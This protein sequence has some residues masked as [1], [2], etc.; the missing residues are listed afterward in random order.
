MRGP[1]WLGWAFAGVMIAL[2]AYCLA[3]LVLTWRWRRPTD[4]PVDALHVLMG[5]AMTGMLAPSLRVFYDGGWEIVFGAGALYFGWR[6]AREFRGVRTPGGPP[7]Q[8]LQH[9]VG[10]AAMVYML[11]VAGGAASASGATGAGGAG[12]SGMAGAGGGHVPTLALAFSLVLFGFVV[13]T[14][15]RL[16]SLAPVTALAR[17]ASPG[18]GPGDAAPGAAAGADPGESPRLPAAPPGR[19]VPLSPRLA[20]CCEIAMGVTMGYMLIVML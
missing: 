1:A 19:A 6:A 12:I 18:P 15:D 14:T 7:G 8:H 9:V 16:T 5:I 2:A 10:C 3:R 11:A 17:R 4:Y 20:A 13:W